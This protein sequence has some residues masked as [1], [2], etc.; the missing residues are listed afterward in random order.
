MEFS[1]MDSDMTLAEMS[2]SIVSY[3][4]QE[5]GFKPVALLPAAPEGGRSNGGTEA[6]APT[7]QQTGAL[8]LRQRGLTLLNLAKDKVCV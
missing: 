2:A 3:R 5:D 6:A 4:E 8:G 7:Q 1:G